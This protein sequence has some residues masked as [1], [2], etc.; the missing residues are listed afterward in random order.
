[1]TFHDNCDGEIMKN[2]GDMYY[3][4]FDLDGFGDPN[5]TVFACEATE[6]LAENSEDCNDQNEDLSRCRG[7]L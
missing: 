7:S 1:M 3:L 6:G 2:L 5:E 4:D